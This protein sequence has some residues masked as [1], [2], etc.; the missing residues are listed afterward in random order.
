MKNSKLKCTIRSIISGFVLLLLFAIYIAI[1]EPIAANLCAVISI[2]LGLLLSLVLD[3]Q[4]GLFNKHL[5]GNLD[6]HKDKI[7]TLEK[8]TEKLGE[9]VEDTKDAL[10]WKIIE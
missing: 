7:G 3:H 2:V 8:T 1:K 9:D 5:Q 10:T 6:E 4:Q